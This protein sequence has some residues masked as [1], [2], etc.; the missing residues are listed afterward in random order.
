MPQPAATFMNADRLV[1]EVEK[2][3]AR[4]SEGDR[5][6]V[7]DALRE[8]LGKERRRIDPTGTVE[9]ERERRVE[10]ETLREILE[11]INR[12]ARLEE[13][14]AEVLKQLSRLVI[15]DS[16]SLA[17]VDSAGNFRIISVRGFPEPSKVVGARFHDPIS[18]AI[19]EHRW[20]IT[21]PDVQADERFQKIEGTATIRSW[22]GIP[23]LVEGD[24]LGVL[25]LDRHRVEPF[26]EEDLHRAKAV[27]FSAS[28]AIRK[29]QLLEQ[30]RRYAAL[31]EQLVAVDQV[32][33]AGR[34]AHAVARA[35]LEAALRIGSYTA[36]LLVL[37]YPDGPR[38]VAAVGDA[39]AAAEGSAAPPELTV[40]TS[41]RLAATA[42]AGV[43][44]TLGIAAPSQ[45]IFIV[46]FETA[47][48]YLG[49]L[50]L[51]DPDGDTPDD[52]LME[53]YAS[54]AAGALLHT[55]RRA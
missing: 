47:E 14:I 3:L 32:V 45:G 11:A 24:V 35:I 8:E 27:A 33:F 23:L 20:P 44:S 40:Q 16:C 6:D 15:Y 9:I 22:A 52:R 10:A 25:C 53:A 50:A 4:L 7:L 54:R 13:T 5:A 17:L 31:M 34:P 55:L 19:R 41:T 18:D 51:L 36:G 2:R 42:L 30:V 43:A 26:D 49:S 38:V 46:P 1:R 37:S 28:A 12:S 39:F 29:A 21:I 48:T